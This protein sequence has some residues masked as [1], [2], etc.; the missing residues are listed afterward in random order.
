M[1]PL[2]LALEQIRFA[3]AYT[4]E[5]IQDLSPEDWFRMPAEGVTHIAWQVGHLAAS[6]Y[7][8]ALLRTRGPQPGDEDLISPAFM[9]PFIGTAVPTAD[10]AAYPSPA[11]IRAVF[12]RVHERVLAEVPTLPESSLN[13]PLMTPH[14]KVKTKLASLFW[15]S[16]HEMLHTGQIGLLRRLFGRPPLW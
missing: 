3:R 1:S 4:L 6:E 9:K 5:R 8:L 12:D 14:P 13:E 16:Q 2:A 7:R 11:E 10:P 15:C